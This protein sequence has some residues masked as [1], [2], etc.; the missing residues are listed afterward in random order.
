MLR[1]LITCLWLCL[2]TVFKTKETCGGEELFLQTMLRFVL[3]M[4][5]SWFFFKNGFKNR[6][7]KCLNLNVDHSEKYVEYCYYK[8]SQIWGK[9]TNPRK[10]IFIQ[11]L[12]EQKPASFTT[13]K[14]IPRVTQFFSTR[15]TP[16]TSRA[17]RPLERTRGCLRYKSK[18]PARGNYIRRTRII[19]KRTAFLRHYTNDDS[20]G[21]ATE[22][23][24]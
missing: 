7:E 10:T 6:G 11:T 23:L 17:C 3:E 16:L 18:L 19:S 22:P 15:L 5:C 4:N 24:H 14:E 21:P 2:L 8:I 1:K 9:G 12:Q 13:D 20:L